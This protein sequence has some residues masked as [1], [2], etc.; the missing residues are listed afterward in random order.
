MTEYR[1]HMMRLIKGKV[2]NYVPGM[3]TCREFE[4]FIDDYLEDSLP[5]TQLNR[6]V[7]HLKLCRECREYLAAY[8]DAIN[9]GQSVFE[10]S[11]VDQALPDD[12]PEDLIKAMIDARSE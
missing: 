9:L 7:K 11:A 6:F 1:F 5:A 2:L 8:K 10:K 12:V 4:A 3:I